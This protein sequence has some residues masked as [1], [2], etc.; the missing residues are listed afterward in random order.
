[1]KIKELRLLN[2]TIKQNEQILFEGKTEDVP[3]DLKDKE[4]D[5]IYFEGVDVIVEI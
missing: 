2:I 4:Y 5:K 3:E 1:M